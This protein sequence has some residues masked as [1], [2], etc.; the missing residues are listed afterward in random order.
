MKD[1]SLQDIVHWE[2]QRFA[3][4]LHKCVLECRSNGKF[5]HFWGNCGTQQWNYMYVQWNFFFSYFYTLGSLAGRCWWLEF[6]FSVV[7]NT[8]KACSC[9]KKGL[10]LSKYVYRIST[11]QYIIVIPQPSTFK[12]VVFPGHS[13]QLIP[14]SFCGCSLLFFFLCTVTRGLF[15]FIST[16][17]DLLV[18]GYQQYKVLFLKK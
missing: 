8:C 7:L 3:L 13:S 4:T 15:T 5:V 12:Y 6:V 14:T 2:L 16:N 1:H 11:E 10:L 17:W 9:P 18:N